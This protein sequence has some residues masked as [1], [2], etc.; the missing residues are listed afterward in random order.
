MLIRSVNFKLVGT[1]K[2]YLKSTGLSFYSYHHYPYIIAGIL[3]SWGDRITLKNV[4]INY[5]Q[6]LHFC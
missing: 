4:F 2:C 3:A 1:E 5:T 6:L